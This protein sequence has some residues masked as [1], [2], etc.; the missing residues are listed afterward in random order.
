[1]ANYLARG[2]FCTLTYSFDRRAVEAGFSLRT[3][4]AAEVDLTMGD[5]GREPTEEHEFVTLLYRKT[6]DQS[7]ENEALRELISR[8]AAGTTIL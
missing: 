2:R 1:M 5:L 4:T 3:A 7:E 6:I 8:R